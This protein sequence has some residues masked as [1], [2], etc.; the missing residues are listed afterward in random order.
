LVDDTFQLLMAPVSIG[1]G[2]V[3]PSISTLL[4]ISTPSDQQGF[5]LGIGQS[6]SSFAQAAAPIFI[7][8][9]YDL[10]PIL[11]YIQSGSLLALSMLITLRLT[12]KP[13][14]KVHRSFV[15]KV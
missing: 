10:S 13:V 1:D 2:F 5:I 3:F 6:F 7:G 12:V 15:L 9:L 14:T 8:E 4:S 11:P